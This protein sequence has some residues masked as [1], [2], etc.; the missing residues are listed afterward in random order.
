VIEHRGM[1]VGEQQRR[2]LSGDPAAVYVF[3]PAVA[4]QRIDSPVPI[5]RQVKP[6]R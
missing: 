5:K 6:F 3:R 1:V 4:I 2:A